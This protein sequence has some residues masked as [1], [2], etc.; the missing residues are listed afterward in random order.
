MAR[1]YS[2]D[3]SLTGRIGGVGARVGL[4]NGGATGAGNRGANAGRVS[5][6]KDVAP[7]EVALTRP[8]VLVALRN[9]RRNV[10][11]D[12][13]SVQQRIDIGRLSRA[14]HSG[15][16]HRKKSIMLPRTPSWHSTHLTRR[17]PGVFAA[18]VSHVGASE[19]ESAGN[20]GPTSRTA[21]FAVEQR[22]ENATRTHDERLDAKRRTRTDHIMIAPF[23]FHGHDPPSSPSIQV[24]EC[25][26]NLGYCTESPGCAAY[27][28]GRPDFSIEWC[29]LHLLPWYDIWSSLATAPMTLKRDTPPH[30]P[31]HVRLI[32]IRD[33]TATNPTLTP[34]SPWLCTASEGLHWIACRRSVAPTTLKHDTSCPPCLIPIRPRR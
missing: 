32:P 15:R 16:N 28:R 11:S 12:D 18:N 7:V 17:R 4:P 24:P 26:A 14:Y 20:R 8:L 3:L 25:T 22:K 29:H 21:F 30:A 13:L 1:L 6:R 19:S 34:R 2:I 27:H 9:R 10:P 33:D 23:R 5:A 31:R